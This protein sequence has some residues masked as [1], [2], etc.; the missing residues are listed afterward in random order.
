MRNYSTEQEK[1]WAGSFGDDYII[2]N[3]GEEYLASNLSFFSKA[4]KLAGRPQSLIEFGPNI[5]MNLA[6]IRSLYPG[7]RLHGVEINKKAAKQLSGLIGEENVSVCSVFEYKPPIQYEVAMTKGVLIHI[8]PEKLDIVY[9]KLYE[10]SSK[11]ILICEYYN[12]SPTIITYRGHQ[13][14]LFKRDF[15]GEMLEMFSG[16]SLIDYGFVY[17]RDSGFPQDD[18]TWFLMKK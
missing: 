8:K 18:I 16:L 15:A 1:F 6:A 7:I 12:P 11:Y 5:G 17:R 4:L 9:K 14:R 13:N 2:R 3:K 10:A